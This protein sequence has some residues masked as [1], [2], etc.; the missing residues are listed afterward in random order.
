M[1]GYDLLAN[2]ITVRERAT[3]R[4]YQVYVDA[5]CAVGDELLMVRRR[6]RILAGLARLDGIH[7]DEA[8]PVAEI[9]LL[10]SRLLRLRLSRAVPAGEA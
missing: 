6:G 8:R 2:R 10:D 7:H 4:I 3:G 1:S 5:D 9:G